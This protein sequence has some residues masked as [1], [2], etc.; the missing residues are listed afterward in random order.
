MSLK[1]NNNKVDKYTRFY[2]ESR[3]YK[4]NRVAQMNNPD[5]STN[6]STKHLAYQK[7]CNLFQFYGDEGATLG[8]RETPFITPSPLILLLGLMC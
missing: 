7:Y 8:D 1:V 6:I 2:I 4:L 3:V 5:E